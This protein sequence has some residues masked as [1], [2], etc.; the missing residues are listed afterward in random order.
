MY[1]PI[2]KLEGWPLFEQLWLD[3]NKYFFFLFFLFLRWHYSLPTC[4]GDSE[5]YTYY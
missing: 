5:D 3:I 4:P 1:T 2:D